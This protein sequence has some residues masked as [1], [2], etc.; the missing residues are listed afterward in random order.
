MISYFLLGLS[1]IIIVALL[2][3]HVQR[4]T[5]TNSRALWE[6]VKKSTKQLLDKYYDYDMKKFSDIK[7]GDI[8]QTLLS[9]KAISS[10]IGETYNE[11]ISNLMFQRKKSME[12]LKKGGDIQNVYNILDYDLYVY[13]LK[14]RAMR[15]ILG[16]VSS[17]GIKA[18]EK[19]MSL[20]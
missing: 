19:S 9:E 3:G 4:E 7:D 1:L 17:Q 8:F 12:E 11:Y 20:I 2:Y 6:N 18:K 5:F 15:A 13:T 10:G 14:N 16:I